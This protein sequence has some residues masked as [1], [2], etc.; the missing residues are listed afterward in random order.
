[1]NDISCVEPADVSDRHLHGTTSPRADRIPWAAMAGIIA[2][3]TVFAV[4][5]GLTY[6]LLSFILERQG[7]TSGLIGLSAAMTPLGFI[8][9]APFIP[10]LSRRVGGARLT[11]LCSILAALTLMTI[12]WAQ[13]VWAWMPLRFL[14]GVFANP[15]YVI[16]ETW[17]ISITPA[18]RRGR[19][20]GL[21]S[22][23]VSG[24]FAIGPLSLWLTGT[25][26]WPP[27]AIGIAAFLLCGLIVLAVVPRLPDM[28]G[29]GEAT[30]VGR[31]FALAPLL[32]FAVFTAA[33]FEQTLLSLFAVYGAALGS[34]EERIASLITCFIAGNAVLQILLGR[35][36]ERLSSTR[37]ML[38]CVLA[39]LAS[40]LLLPSAFNSWLIWP[41]VFVWGGV[42]FGIYTLS[43]I[44]LGERFTGQALIAGNATFA[45]VWGIGGIV[46]SPATGLAMQLIGHQGLPL[47]LGLLSSVLAAL[48]MARR[49]RG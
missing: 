8:L 7:R 39:C 23:I 45:L 1:M 43:L 34:A 27:F 10:A 22:S 19:I 38:F 40:C 13:D 35:L 3:V 46:G 41:L 44:Q 28:P 25:E 16:S 49:R 17:L 4:A 14:L 12:A 30:T 47:S 42:S 24:G 37:M 18:P 21:Y 29:E 26:G 31:F 6:P 32:L 48:M 36:A 2:T 33:A 15:L 5:Q 11:I 20:M 9:S